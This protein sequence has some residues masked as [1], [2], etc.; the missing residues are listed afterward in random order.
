MSTGM[1][2]FTMLRSHGI[3][4]STGA[5]KSLLFGL[6]HL[7]CGQQRAIGCLFGVRVMKMES[8]D[9]KICFLKLRLY[10]LT[11]NGLPYCYKW[12]TYSCFSWP[13]C[14]PPA[15]QKMFNCWFAYTLP[16]KKFHRARLKEFWKVGKKCDILSVFYQLRINCIFF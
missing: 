1:V 9:A 11:K 16:L 2:H 13:L 3:L 6:I 5:N 14:N 4:T 10:V 8:T 12:V 7:I 15:T